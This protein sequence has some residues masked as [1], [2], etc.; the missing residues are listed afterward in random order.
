MSTANTATCTTAAA[1][2]SNTTAAISRA[3]TDCTTDYIAS[4]NAAS[5]SITGSSAVSSAA[6]TTATIYMLQLLSPVLLL[7]ILLLILLMKPDHSHN[8][9]IYDQ[10]HFIMSL[11][12]KALRLKAVKIDFALVVSHRH[13]VWSPIQFCPLLSFPIVYS[14]VLTVQTLKYP[15]LM[16]SNAWTGK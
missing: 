14:S 15:F 5:T 7:E 11:R 3:T 16:C 13:P 4:T 10:M 9:Q 8:Q 1:T 2:D 6:T 12:S